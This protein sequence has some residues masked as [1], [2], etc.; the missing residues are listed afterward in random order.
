MIRRSLDQATIC[1]AAST[2]VT[3]WVVSRR[4]CSGSTPAGG[5][6]FGDLDESE[7]HAWQE[8]ASAAPRAFENYRAEA[9][10]Q[11]RRAAR[12]VRPR[13]GSTIVRVSAA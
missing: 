5:V 2:L 4:R 9:Q 13:R 6:V 12:L 1:Q 3:S 11:T 8:I 10:R 7:A